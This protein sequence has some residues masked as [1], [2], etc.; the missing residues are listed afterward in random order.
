M[1]LRTL[2]TAALAAPLALAACSDSTGTS[3]PGQ[4]RLRFGVTSGAQALAAPANGLA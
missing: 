3:A 4:V 2:I 1:K